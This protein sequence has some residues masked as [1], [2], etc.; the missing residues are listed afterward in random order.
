MRIKVDK[1]SPV[2]ETVFENIE[3]ED[4]LYEMNSDE[5]LEDSLVILEDMAVGNS[6][7]FFTDDEEYEIEKLEDEN[8]FEEDLF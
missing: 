6:F 5:E 1:I 8:I 3:A 2:Y 4:F 7:I